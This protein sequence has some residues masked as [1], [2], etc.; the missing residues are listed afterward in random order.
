MTAGTSAKSKTDNPIGISAVCL[1]LL[2]QDP[3]G[4]AKGCTA[5]AASSEAIPL[6]QIK[7]QTLISFLRD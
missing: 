5:L 4:Y 6:T 2:G 7:A 3:E 1:I